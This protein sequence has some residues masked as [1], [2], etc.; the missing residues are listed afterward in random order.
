MGRVR[1]YAAVLAAYTVLLVILGKSFAFL[2]SWLFLPVILLL[3]LPVW[4]TIGG[5]EYLLVLETLAFFA[6]A[7]ALDARAP[8]AGKWFARLGLVLCLAQIT[9]LLSEKGVGR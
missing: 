5:F 9:I 1:R 2:I 4:L 8:K 7:F 3:T 6:I